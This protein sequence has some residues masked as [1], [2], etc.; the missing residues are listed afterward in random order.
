MVEQTRERG[1]RLIPRLTCR[2]I[3][4]YRVDAKGAQEVEILKPTAI[5]GAS[6]F[7]VTNHNATLE[8]RRAWLL[9]H[10]I[11]VTLRFIRN[12]AEL[13]VGAT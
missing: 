10:A 5:P 11:V 3:L 9:L 8:G 4:F 12:Y 1:R 6:I 7:Q 13:A 2:A